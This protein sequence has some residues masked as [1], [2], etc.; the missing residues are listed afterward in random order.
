[1]IFLKRIVLIFLGLLIA[2][3]IL[4]LSMQTA[5]FCISSF[6]NYKNNK[7]LK[8]KS[9]YAVMCLGESTTSLAYP[10]ELQKILNKKHP[11]KFSVIDCGVPAV[12][13]D[14]ILK[15]LD[16]NIDKYKP[17]I[18]VCMMGINNGFVSFDEIKKKSNKKI[19][20]FK[21][22]K[23]YNLLKEH[24]KASLKIK[25]AY[26]DNSPELNADYAYQL[27]FQ[28]KYSASAKI[29]EEI[30]E[31]GKNDCNLYS[32]LAMLYFYHLNRKDSAYEMALN[33]IKT[34]KQVS[35]YWKQIIYEILIEH[36]IKK[37]KDIKSAKRFINLLVNDANVLFSEMLYL[38][39][40]DYMTPEQKTRFAKKMYFYK[41]ALDQYYGAVAVEM[42]EEKDYEKAEEYFRTAEELR[43]KYPN[44]KTYGLYKLI[45]KKLTD[46]NIKVICM[47]YPVRSIEPLKQMLKN[48]QYY[49]RIEFLSNEGNFKNL[50]KEKQFFEIF[51]DQ[52][53]G[54]F[55]HYKKEGSILI[56]ENVME[57]IEKVLR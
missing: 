47:Q 4:E 11:G 50:L 29:C 36:N 42:M 14:F 34:N 52:F 43:L 26:A 12:K 24:L 39:I 22:Y 23:L 8:D 41:N 48:E 9:Q 40:K 57:N 27:Y 21:L 54:D 49:G 37:R 18:A 56:A 30:L 45:I 1:M 44:E 16:D 20:R 25:E 10:C 55:G 35:D 38:G 6:Q 15:N 46:N 33:I 51:S 7:A 32:F 28:K 17:D 31:T 53:A 13:L 3:I 2:L 19:E 5:G